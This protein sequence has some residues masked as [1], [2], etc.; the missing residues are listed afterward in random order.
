MDIELY[1][2]GHIA[3]ITCECCFII[4]WVSRHIL[5]ELELY[6]NLWVIG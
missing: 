1:K 4:L 5:V 3:S 2:V 6:M